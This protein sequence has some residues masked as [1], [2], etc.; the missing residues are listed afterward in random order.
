MTRFSKKVTFI[1]S[2][3]DD[4]GVIGF[5]KRYVTTV[6]LLKYRKS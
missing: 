1:I 6:I 4:G 2:A 3:A 5:T